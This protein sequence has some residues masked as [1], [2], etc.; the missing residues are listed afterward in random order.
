MG[1]Q[2]MSRFDYIAYDDEAKELQVEFKALFSK[3]EAQIDAFPNGRAKALA[4]T[5]LEESYMW[6]GKA[7]RDGQIARNGSAEL[8][9][10][11]SN[12]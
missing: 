4:L 5:A 8:E 9:E 2:Q 11:R 6:V 1:L 12:S 7:I 10:V 3:V